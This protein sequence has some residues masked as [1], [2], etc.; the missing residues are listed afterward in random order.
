[1]LANIFKA[2]DIRGTYPDKVNE[3]AAWRIGFGVG[4]FLKNHPERPKSAAGQNVLVSRDMRTSSPQLCQALSD[5]IRATGMNV[6]DLGMAD[7]SMMYYAVETLGAAGG[8]QT[9]ASHNPP[10]YNGFKISGPMSKPVGGN[11]GL[12]D[13]QQLAENATPGSP[14]S[15]KP[16]GSYSTRDIWEGYRTHVQRFFTPPKRPIKAFVDGSN[17]MAGKLLP[18]VFTG[19]KNLDIIPVN[20][21]I[22]GSFVH[23]PNPLVPENMVPTQ[24]GVKQ[25]KADLGAC[26]DGDADR[27]MI[28]DEQGAI[29]GCDHLT[30]L[31]C[32]HFLTQAP[33]SAVIYDLRSSKVVEETIRACGG[34]PKKCCVGH[35]FMKALLREIHGI[36]GGELSG[37]FYFRNN[38][39]ADSGAI[40]FA[41][42]VSV[43]GQ[44]DKPL[45]ELVKPFRKYPQSGEINFRTADK[46]AVLSAIKSTF[47]DGNIDNL[48]G[49]SIDCWDKKGYWFNVRA[50][51]TEPLLRLNAEAKEP[52]ALDKLL[53]Q[54]KPML[55]E[56]AKGH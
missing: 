55:G 32:K 44:A 12:K 11:T 37:H 53:Q 47:A 34:Q 42:V 5:G 20:F 18:A 16:T 17:G 56:E 39:F 46:E 24:Q 51:N 19:L 15:I 26:F 43:L 9:T 1:M 41:S 10:Q 4:T 21:E 2:Y 49:I 25:H 31:L 50:S 48:D 35:V 45:S 23:E 36:F 13:I 52:A 30:A 22:T 27:C 8:V 14:G 40:A 54:L 38:A 3:D 29:L 28:T 33:G 6:I 7:T